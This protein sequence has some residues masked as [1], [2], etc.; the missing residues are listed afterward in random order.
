VHRSKIEK[1]DRKKSPSD[2]KMSRNHLFNGNNGNP[3]QITAEM[4]VNQ[5]SELKLVSQV[6]RAYFSLDSESSNDEDKTDITMDQ[7]KSNKL[8]LPMFSNKKIK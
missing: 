4:T 3:V 5:T 6:S 2:R 8:N 7:S 1:S